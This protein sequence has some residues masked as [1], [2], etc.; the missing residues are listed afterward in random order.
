MQSFIQAWQKACNNIGPSKLVIPKGTFVVAQVL[1]SG[2]CQ[3]QVTVELQGTITADPDPSVFPNQELIVF[4]QVEGAI[5]TGTGSINVNQPQPPCDS[6]KSFTF[7]EVM[8]VSQYIL[9]LLFF[10]RKNLILI[11]YMIIIFTLYSY[12]FKFINKFF[13][14]K[15]NS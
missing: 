12:Q 14:L 11:M 3:S 2:P 9:P 4:Q 7:M 8:P 15:T 5:F 13:L 6:E 10:G 1:F